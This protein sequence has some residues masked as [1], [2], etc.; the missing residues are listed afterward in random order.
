MATKK[1]AEVEPLIRE[2]AVGILEN[3]PVSEMFNWIQE[4]SIETIGRMRALRFDP[5][6][7]E[8]HKL[9]HWLDI[10]IAVCQVSSDDS[11]DMKQRWEE[12][13]L[14]VLWEAYEGFSQGR[15]SRR[16]H[17]SA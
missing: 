10:K 9:I 16:C 15:D 5:P 6:Y 14:Q 12:L 3:L 11:I 13:Q 1:L 7:Q 8:R 4:V 2:R 17:P